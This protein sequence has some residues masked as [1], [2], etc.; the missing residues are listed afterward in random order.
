VSKKGLVAKY[1]FDAFVTIDGKMK[2]IVEKEPGLNT[3]LYHY[4]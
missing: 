2:E 4:A 1:N 3:Q